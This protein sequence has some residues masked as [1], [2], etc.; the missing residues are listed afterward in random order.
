[1][2]DEINKN[3]QQ[4][5]EEDEFITIVIVSIKNLFSTLQGKNKYQKKDYFT[6]VLKKTFSIILKM[7]L[8]RV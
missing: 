7:I 4:K 1:M 5:L 3:P 8:S 2:D 6:R